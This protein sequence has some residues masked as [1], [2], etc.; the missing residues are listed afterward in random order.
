MPTG[1]PAY[2]LPTVASLSQGLDR[3]RARV[4]RDVTQVT[5]PLPASSES[6]HRLHRDLRRLGTGIAVWRELLPEEETAVAA[7][8]DRRIRGLARLAG[9]TRDRDVAA[10]LLD[11]VASLHRKGIDGRSW[12]RF[13]TELQDE[14]RSGRT[15]IKRSLRAERDS[16]LFDDVRRLLRATPVLSR[17]ARLSRLFSR[18]RA[19]HVARLVRARRRAARRPSMRRLHR[20]RVR[21]RELR[22]FDDIASAAS[23]PG[24]PDRVRPDRRL[25]ERLGRLHDLDVLLSILGRSAR[26]TGWTLAL[27]AERR[28]RRAAIVQALRSDLPDG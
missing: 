26:R 15:R 7:R 24:S 16:G 10:E 12:R 27:R 11:G 20:L 5:R 22:Q 8:I 18:L 25:Q 4:V 9:R 21:I 28:R 14:A 13:R 19:E 6:L 23:Y 3:R 2:H 1:A 17:E